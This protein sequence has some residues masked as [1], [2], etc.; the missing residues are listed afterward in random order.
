MPGLDTSSN[1]APCLK[2]ENQ[3]D[4]YHAPNRNGHH[5][6]LFN[7]EDDPPDEDKQARPV[8]LIVDDEED[9]CHLLKLAIQHIDCEI[10]IAYDGRQ[11]LDMIE[12][13]KPD[14][15]LLDIK[16]PNVNGYEVL[17]R[18]QQNPDLNDIRVI[19]MTSLTADDQTDTDEGWAVRLGVEQFISKPFAA[20]KFVEIVGH[21]LGLQP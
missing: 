7:R 3:P 5:M 6:S 13:R 21:Q 8:I 16:M 2:A 1:G 12:E 11:A 20:D 17:S 18:I 15:M 14:L 19:V 10:L 4:T 9:L